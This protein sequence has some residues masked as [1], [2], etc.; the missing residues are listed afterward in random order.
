MAFDLSQTDRLLETTRSV[1]KR[2]DLERPVPRAVIEECLNIAQQAP[3]GSNTQ[4]WRWLVVTDAAK[5]ARLA[6]LY[7]MTAEPYLKGGGLARTVE[8]ARATDP[9]HGEQTARVMDS[10][11]YLMDVLARVPVHIIPCMQAP[12][13]M[14]LGHTAGSSVYPAVWSLQLALHSRGLGSC[15]TTLH[16][17]QE[18]AAAEL[19]GI[20]A[21]IR[22]FA[23]LPVA[24]IKGGPMKRAER[25]PLRESL[26]WDHW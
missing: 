21:D 24:Y 25:K 17:G 16:L 13:G 9:A 14:P 15:L 18:R 23:L 3:S 12:A 8:Q 22:Q 26:H 4:N 1:R 11:V 20:P 2:L 7:R 10:A 5:R 19:L 6:E